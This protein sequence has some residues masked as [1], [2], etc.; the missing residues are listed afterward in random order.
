MFDPYSDNYTHNSV[1]A[2]LA[3]MRSAQSDAISGD[4][5][6][7]MRD[8]S[9][10]SLIESQMRMQRLQ[11]DML[12]Q[13]Q[14]ASVQHWSQQ[15]ALRQSMYGT[16]VGMPGA[17]PGT[18]GLGNRNIG[19]TSGG[20]ATQSLGGLISDAGLSRAINAA[21]FGVAYPGYS[22]AFGASRAQVMQTA[23]EEINQ[24]I[25]DFGRGFGSNFLPQFALDR[26]FLGSSAFQGSQGDIAR[27]TAASF[28]NVRVGPLGDMRVDGLGLR[29]RGSTV[30]NITDARMRS[31]EALHKRR[32]Y[33]LTGEDFDNIQGFMDTAM[34]LD[35]SVRQAMLSGDPETIGKTTDSL[36]RA[37][38]RLT[39]ELKVNTAEGRRIFEAGAKRGYS[40]EQISKMASFTGS[41]INGSAL[42]PNV[43]NDVL[44]DL[45]TYGRSAD[46]GTG[47]SFGKRQL[48]LAMGLRERL[49]G[50][51]PA[52][53]AELF[54]FGG[55]NPDEAAIIYQQQQQQLNANVTRRFGAS[56]GVASLSGTG[57]TRG[58]GGLMGDISSAY[59]NDP[60]AY[61]RALSD[62]ETR[63]QMENNGTLSAY[64]YAKQV[65]GTVPG[66]MQDPA[67]VSVF[68]R[69]L[70]VDI[71]RAA[72]LWRQ[73]NRRA[74]AFS[75]FKAS[76]SEIMRAQDRLSS[77]A[78]ISFSDSEMRGIADKIGN[79]SLLSILE[80][81]SGTDKF[82]ASGRN[83]TKTLLDSLGLEQN[84]EG[85]TPVFKD[86]LD[87]SE[88][89]N[90]IQR[91]RELGIDENYL[92]DLKV[93]GEDDTPW[94]SAPSMG[95]VGGALSAGLK[96]SLRS[97]SSLRNAANSLISSSNDPGGMTDRLIRTIAEASG[98]EGDGLSTEDITRFISKNETLDMSKISENERKRLS[99]AFDIFRQ[100]SVDNTKSEP[101]RVIISNVEK[102]AQGFF[103][104]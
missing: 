9:A 50:Q 40:T 57:W 69:T 102:D 72:E 63:Q 96:N 94:M 14:A 16:F 35:P 67:G 93:L 44:L 18:M 87:K 7:R 41:M 26:G 45:S 8:I 56:L 91:A 25:G 6:S 17:L 66:G 80:A 2:Q 28:S 36:T 51:G 10:A 32:G 27:S 53:M 104:K 89:K 29:L 98:I 1:N 55:S 33:S 74:D 97:Q 99:L 100:Q 19:Y 37:I 77:E 62:P 30:Q 103:G 38:E 82:Q 76:S 42:A 81:A 49:T 12:R 92:M 4:I 22:T 5:S 58:L 47:T 59:A 43:L 86:T 71:P 21:T 60:M 83:R 13:M 88:I 65:A 52:G 90:I 68:A 34:V 95:Q 79:G 3:Q 48:G 15:T 101:I 84:S 24:R 54:R 85:R 11:Q 20:A 70:G 61:I 31:V 64:T 46:Y 75:G 39:Q 23:Q 78:G 73:Y